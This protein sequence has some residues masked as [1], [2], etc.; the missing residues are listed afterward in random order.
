[1][2]RRP[3]NDISVSRLKRKPG[4]GDCNV[5]SRS[6][7]RWVRQHLLLLDTNVGAGQKG[8]P[9]DVAETGYAA[10]MKG[11]GDVV[12]GLRNKIQ[13]AMANV[14]PASFLAKQHR[15]MA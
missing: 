7:H 4:V 10:M 6:R 5:R 15:N 3:G 12:S 13:S 2:E 1:M 8:R 14:T 11:E 9:V